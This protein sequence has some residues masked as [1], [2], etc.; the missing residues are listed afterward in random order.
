M[1]VINYKHGTELHGRI[2]EVSDNDILQSRALHLW[3]DLDNAWWKPE[4]GA[5]TTCSLIFF[6]IQKR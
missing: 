3:I 6:K 5:W 2:L 4:I 1:F